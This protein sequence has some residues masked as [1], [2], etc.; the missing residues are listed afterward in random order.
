MNFTQVSSYVGLIANSVVKGMNAKKAILG[1]LAAVPVV[2]AGTLTGAG[3][4]DA[5]ALVGNFNFNGHGDPSTTATL[6]SNKVDFTEPGLIG[7]SL[8]S[9]S[10]TNFNTA[11]I[12]DLSPLVNNT[13]NPFID[14]V[15]IGDPNVEDGKDVFNVFTTN[16]FSYFQ[17]TNNLVEISLGVFGEFVSALGDKSIGEGLLTFQAIGNVAGIKSQIESNTG[18]NAAFSGIAFSTA[19]VPEPASILGLGLVAGSLVASRRRKAN[20]VS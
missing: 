11:F 3:S 4:A 8:Q 18:V 17:K 10:F 19:S 13:S 6:T 9:G 7:L 14:L 2:V 15:A 12:N 5:A 1:S 16:G 20:Q